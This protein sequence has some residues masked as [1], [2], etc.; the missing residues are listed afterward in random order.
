MS[1][2]GSVREELNP[3]ITA[4]RREVQDMIGASESPVVD[5]MR[6][7]MVEFKRNVDRV[8]SS[9]ADN[10]SVVLEPGNT[11]VGVA[12]G[13]IPYNPIA[14]V[15]ARSNA[16]EPERELA[17]VHTTFRDGELR[18]VGGMGRKRASVPV[19]VGPPMDQPDQLKTSRGGLERGICTVA[20]S[21][22]FVVCHR[23]VR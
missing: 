15:N 9:G 5:A 12:G 13:D 14:V 4:L 20:V 17:A 16:G 18:N 19:K 7:M 1:D 23:H 8:E 21:S 6:S 10:G 22:V 11:G 3:E 2:V